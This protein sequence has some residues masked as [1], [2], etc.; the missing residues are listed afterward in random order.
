M[1]SEYQLH[2]CSAR[3]GAC[4]AFMS[5]AVMTV[6][7]SQMFDAILCLILIVTLVKLMR[8][9]RLSLAMARVIQVGSRQG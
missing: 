7:N 4:A 2:V 8:K 3:L 6:D 5:P 9:L 1:F